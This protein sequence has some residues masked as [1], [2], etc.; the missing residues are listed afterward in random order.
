V[1]AAQE[2]IHE[3]KYDGYRMLVIREKDRVRLISRGG[4]DWANRFPLIAR[5]RSGCL[6]SIS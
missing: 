3:I 4:R 2:W 6:R 5:L 1:P